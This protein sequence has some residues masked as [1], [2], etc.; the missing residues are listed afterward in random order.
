[1]QTNSMLVDPKNQRY[2]EELDKIAVASDGRLVVEWYGGDE[3]VPA[4]TEFEAVDSGALDAGQNC[5][6]YWKKYFL[7]A[8]LFTY[9]SGGLSGVEF[10]SWMMYGGGIELQDKMIEGWNVHLIGMGGFITPGEIW[11]HSDRELKTPDD[12]V[13][14]KMRVAGDGGEILSRMGT[15]C[16]HFPSTEIYES[17]ERG[18]IDA[19]ECSC[20]TTDWARGLQEVGQY[21]YLSFSRQGME[22]MCSFI[23]PDRWAELTPDLRQI[24][25]TTMRGAPMK[26][27][28]L[29]VN[30]DTDAIQKFIDYGSTVE[31]LSPEIEAAFAAEAEA[32]YAE[33]SAEDPF[34]AEVYNS[35]TEFKKS[36]RAAFPRL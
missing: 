21:I 25:E 33:R 26:V 4:E 18:V 10:H 17:A 31:A 20:P 19:Y 14:L 34:Y 22:Y 27:Y 36:I 7:A 3:I 6:M 12:L 16:V 29:Y 9:V 11:V 8:P 32:F 2:G 24:V 28:H 5:P 35:M 13:G 30:M 1:M 15:A 23:N